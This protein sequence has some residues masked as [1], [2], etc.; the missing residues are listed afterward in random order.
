MIGFSFSSVDS[1]DSVDSLVVL[2][3]SMAS[4]L[5]LQQ[6]FGYGFKTDTI[7]KKQKSNF[8]SNNYM[9]LHSFVYILLLLT[10][11]TD[12]MELMIGDNLYN[13]EHSVPIII[14]SGMIVKSFAKGYHAYKNL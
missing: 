10:V 5:L 13:D 6:T 4:F 1:V 2:V 8:Y 14:T 12:K 7:P 9:E 3:H 11:K